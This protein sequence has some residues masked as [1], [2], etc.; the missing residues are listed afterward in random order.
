MHTHAHPQVTEH[1]LYT[2]TLLHNAQTRTALLDSEGHSVPVVCLDVELDNALHTRMHV[3]QPYPVGHHAQAHAAAHGLKK[4]MR[5][6]VQAPL[7]D[8][9]LVLNN[10]VAIEPLPASP[11]AST[12]NQEPELWQ[13]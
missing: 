11:E 8:L 6:R 2:G 5:V 4:G 7:I 3:E 13:A 9:R 10:T 12:T 1:A